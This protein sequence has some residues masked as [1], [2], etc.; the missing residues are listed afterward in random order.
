MGPIS[1]TVHDQRAFVAFILE[2][3]SATYRIV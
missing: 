3:A 2:K 1:A